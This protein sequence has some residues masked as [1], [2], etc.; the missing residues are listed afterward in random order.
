MKQNSY[1]KA[2]CEID[3]TNHSINSFIAALKSLSIPLASSDK[4]KYHY[5]AYVSISKLAFLIKI[6]VVPIFNKI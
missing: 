1:D 5:V 6:K 2:F 4:F 3:P